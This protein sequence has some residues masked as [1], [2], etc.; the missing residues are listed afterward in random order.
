MGDIRKGIRTG[1]LNLLIN[2]NLDTYSIAK[3]C[4]VKNRQNSCF[5]E[6]CSLKDEVNVKTD[7][8]SINLSLQSRMNALE[9]K[10]GGAV[11]EDNGYCTHTGKGK[12]PERPF[13]E[14]DI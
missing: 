2:L 12:G 5:H 14:S 10:D 8:V 4:T 11:S 3:N 13:W 9:E 1:S 7:N 6:V